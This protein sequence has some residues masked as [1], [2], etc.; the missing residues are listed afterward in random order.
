[1]E[2]GIDCV[3]VDYVADSIPITDVTQ[4]DR[5]LHLRVDGTK[6]VFDS[7][8]IALCLVE[9]D[10]AGRPKVGDLAAQLGSNR[11]CR[12]RDKDRPADYALSDRC[13]IESDWRTAQ[14]ILQ[15]QI[16]TLRRRDLAI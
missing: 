15:R 9:G 7:K 13:I 8:E 12:S 4:H 14:E 6:L 5:E 10:Q 16:A 3:S 2:N 11:P 1:M